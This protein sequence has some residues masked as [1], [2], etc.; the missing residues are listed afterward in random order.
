[1]LKKMVD[2]V[3]LICSDEEERLILKKWSLNE[4]YPEYRG[5]LMFDG[6]SE[7]QHDLVQCSIHHKGMIE[8][9]ISESIE[10]INRQIEEAEDNGY[11]S[12]KSD[13]ISKR[14]SIKSLIQFEEKSFKS[15]DE[16]KSHLESVKTKAL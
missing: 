14:K 12:L 5:H 9:V 11:D 3:E 7:P 10:K 6:I 13:L 1:M 16:M 4:K 2:G 8:Q 15:V